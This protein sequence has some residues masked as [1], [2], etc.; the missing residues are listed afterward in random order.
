MGLFEKLF[1][2]RPPGGDARAFFKTLTAYQPVY[3]T[4]RGG[5]YE[6]ELT[7]AAIATFA[8]HCSK[9][10]LELVGDA[11][12]ELARVLGQQPNPWM[13]ASKFLARLATIYMVQNNAFIVPMEDVA[14]RLVGYFP[15]LPQQSSIRDVGGEPYLLYRFWGGQSAAIELSRAGILTQHQYEDDFFGSDNRPLAPTLQVMHAQDEGIINGIKNATTIRFL[16]RLAGNL[17]KKDIDAERER[18]A[19]DNLAGNDTGVMMFDSKYADIKQIE[20]TALVVNPRQQELIRQSVFSY[21]G[22]NEKI[23]TNTYTEDEWNA[24]YEG[25]IEP[26]AIQLSLV[27]TAMTFTPAEIAQ[28]AGIIAT[29]NRLQYASNNTKL[30]IVTQLFDRGF[31]THNMGLEIF[32][33]PPVENGDRYFIRKEYAEVSEVS[34]LNT[35][36]TEP[37]EPKEGEDNG[38]HAGD[39]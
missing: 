36:D 26:F 3:T 33:M 32:N 38:D 5:L 21:F 28:G 22:T 19:A 20:S 2:R 35:G 8:R 7:R 25:S 1:P 9:L 13:D 31:L 10:H 37:T 39:P 4:Y 14:G 12:P 24:Y 29:A 27:L 30:N 16:A 15:V 23:L 11:R 17:K 6:M 34:K 18:F